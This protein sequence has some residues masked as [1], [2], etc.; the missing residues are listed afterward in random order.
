MHLM[1]IVNR[2][3]SMYLY[4]YTYVRNDYARSCAYKKV[5]DGQTDNFCSI[6]M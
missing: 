5:F 2:Q 3:L 6:I 1:R 4:I